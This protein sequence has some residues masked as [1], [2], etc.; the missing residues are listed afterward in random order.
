M[1]QFQQQH[2][3]MKQ[4]PNVGMANQLIQLL[5]LSGAAAA[6]AGAAGTAAAAIGPM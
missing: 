2:V 5:P 6:A 3:N 1:K 4:Y